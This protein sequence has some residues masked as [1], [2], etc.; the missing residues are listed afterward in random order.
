VP[1]VLQML[2]DA[3][4]SAAVDLSRLKLVIGG[5]AL[6]SG[7]ARAARARGIDAFVGYGMSETCPLLTLAQLQPG[8]DDG[9]DDARARWLGKAG[10]P[11]PLVDLRIVDEQVRD[12]DESVAS[13]GEIVARTPWLTQGYLGRPE[14]SDALWRGGYLHT[15]DVG[16]FDRGYLTICDRIRDVI[17][18]GGEWISTVQ[19]EDLISL[20]AAV[21]ECAVIGVA[22][23]KWGERPLA[24][25][26]AKSGATLD[27]G[28]IRA[29][30]LEHAESGAISR[31]AVPREILIV[32]AL[33]KTSV[34]K[35]DKKRLRAEYGRD[36]IAGRTDER[37]GAE[38]ASAR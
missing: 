10:V 4:G 33:P 28:A 17:K 1:T 3:P 23:D 37:C 21:G 36:P 30:L 12:V 8:L 38:R 35:I 20:H 31:F 7:C 18:S 19:L 13:S 25:V 34:G 9:D 2:L 11:L 5:S 32:T 24:F 27:V 16:Y 14:A 6:P 22:D 29:M 15:Q 26:V